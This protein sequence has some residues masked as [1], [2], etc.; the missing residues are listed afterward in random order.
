MNAAPATGAGTGRRLRALAAPD[1]LSRLGRRFIGRL[2]FLDG[3]AVRIVPMNFVLHEGSV[4]L[5]MAEGAVL[6]AIRG[7]DV[8]FE[9]D[10]IDLDDHAGWSVVVH[11][12]AEQVSG[13]DEMDV[14]Q[15]LPLRPWAPGDRDRFVRIA[16]TSITGR[17]L[18]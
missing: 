9:V 18:S 13:T 6:D 5:R 11:G 1:C 7:A 14:L 2:A 8:A 16:P 3:G 15:R 17:D 10:D 12:R 4:V